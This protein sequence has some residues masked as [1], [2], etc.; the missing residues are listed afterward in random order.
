MWEEREQRKEKRKA[1]KQRME[2]AYER[3][4]GGGVYAVH[5]EGASAERA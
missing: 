2:Q 5:T 4:I 3:A 1:R